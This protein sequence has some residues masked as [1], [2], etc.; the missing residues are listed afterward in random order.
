MDAKYPVEKGLHC[1]SDIGE[2]LYCGNSVDHDEKLHSTPSS[3]SLHCYSI[4]SY[5]R[6]VSL[7]IAFAANPMFLFYLVS[8]GSYSFEVVT[9]TAF[10]VHLI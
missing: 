3:L 8:L 1:C 7:R 10:L 2:I 4:Y 5:S 9:F 6:M